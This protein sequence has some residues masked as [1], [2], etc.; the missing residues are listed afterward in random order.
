MEK[1]K[2]ERKGCFH[3]QF[4]IAESHFLPN[5]SQKLV[6]EIVPSNVH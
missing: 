1:P 4:A 2:W 6:N 5:E 3:C